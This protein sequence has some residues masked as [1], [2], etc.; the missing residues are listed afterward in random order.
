[1]K[2]KDINWNQCHKMGYLDWK[3]S[4]SDSLRWYVSQVGG[5][6]ISYDSPAVG[7]ILTVQQQIPQISLISKFIH[8]RQ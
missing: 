7:L 4:P 5:D 3:L 2:I 8:L 1:M 6:E